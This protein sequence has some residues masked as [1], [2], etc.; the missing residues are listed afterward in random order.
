MRGVV[1][2]TAAL[3][4][5]MATVAI[6]TTTCPVDHVWDT[7]VSDCVPCDVCKDFP[8]TPICESCRD[9]MTNEQ[10][11]PG[12]VYNCPPGYEW[13]P[14]NSDCLECDVCDSAPDTSICSKCLAKQGLSVAVI[15]GIS[16]SSVIAFVSILAVLVYAWR[17]YQERHVAYPVQTT[18]RDDT[19]DYQATVTNQRIN[20]P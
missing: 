9:A 19:M 6:A 12:P 2:S 16:V 18:D 15:A 4:V 14:I 3:Y 20:Q 10:P 8:A 17:G 11:T 5:F 13:E 7:V 1:P